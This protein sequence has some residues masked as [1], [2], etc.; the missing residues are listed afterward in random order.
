MIGGRNAVNAGISLGSAPIGKT[1]ESGKE[2]ESVGMW[3]CGSVGI[4]ECGSVGVWEC[5][6]VRVWESRRILGIGT[7][8]RIL[9]IGIEWEDL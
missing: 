1:C 7:S 3:E 4:W 6:N 8:R 2:F 5:R 9:G